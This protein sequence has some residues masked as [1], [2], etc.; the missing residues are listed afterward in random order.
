MN[1][2]QIVVCGTGIVGLAAALGMVKDG[3]KTMLL[4][5]RKAFE[6]ARPDVYYPRVYALSAES[7]RF[8]QALG[9]WDMLDHTRITP[10]ES[11]QVYGDAGGHVDLQAWQA[12]QSSMAWI[13]ESSELERVLQQAV[14]VFGVTWHEDRFV[15]LRDGVVHTESGRQIPAALVVGA[16]GADSPVRQAAGISYRSKPYH[17]TGLVTHLTAQRPHNNAAVQ[18]FLSDGVLALL[19][20]PDTPDGHQVS[21]VWSMS[22][23][24]ASALLAMPQ[25]ERDQRLQTLLFAAS[26]GVFGNLTVRSGVFGFP[27]FLERSTMV[28]SGVA[29]AGDAAHRV[30]PLA[31]QGLNLG[32]GDVAQLVGILRDKPEGSSPGQANLLRRYRRTRAEPVLAM[33]LITDGLFRLFAAQSAPIVTVRNL[34]MQLVDRL[35]F[36]KRGLI[37]GASGEKPQ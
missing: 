1:T 8:L 36:I 29:L 4:G 32:L 13:I 31:G 25:L 10:V 15:D 22:D 9:V 26:G 14:R 33:S 18:W 20:M 2:Q 30:H 17:Q 12:V 28:A 16:D 34:G 7:Q 21:M 11:M 35:P 24:E 6:A 23:K 19:P 37:T 27:L 5:P 3:H